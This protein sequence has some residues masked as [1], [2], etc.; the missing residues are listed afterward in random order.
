MNN[1]FAERFSNYNPCEFDRNR[2]YSIGK[3][4]SGN[5]EYNPCEFD[6][7]KFIN[8]GRKYENPSLHDLS[9]TKISLRQ[10][11][12]NQSNLLNNSR[13]NIND[14]L[15]TL[16]KEIRLEELKKEIFLDEY[17]IIGNVY[18][19]AESALEDRYIS[20]IGVY[21]LA[22]NILEFKK[23]VDDNKLIRQIV[24]ELE[25]EHRIHEMNPEYLKFIL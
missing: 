24:L 13:V 14:K 3:K 15:Y 5:T 19:K 21:E 16:A 22:N 4:I 25:L 8:I 20:N 7:N 6:R 2:W 23:F 1:Y 17:I 11:T 18:S 10:S 9:E 12:N